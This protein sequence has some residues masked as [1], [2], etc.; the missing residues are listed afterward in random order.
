MANKAKIIQ[1]GSFEDHRGRMVFAND[2]DM[3][4]VKRFYITTPSENH[5]ERAW[6]G[7]KIEHK[8]FLCIKGSFEVKLI[9]PNDWVN[10]ELGLKS[11]S[12]KLS[13]KDISVLHIPGG[14][15]NGFK[16]MVPGSKMMIYS[17]LSLE[18]SKADDHRF[19]IDQWPL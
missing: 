19:P 15:I 4:Y 1:G 3:S 18:E 10:P 5:T 7:H 9:K 17:S 8:W 12:F 2:F 6:Q 16:S 14:Y 11:E 13:E